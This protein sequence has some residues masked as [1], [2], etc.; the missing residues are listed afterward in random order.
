[1][2]KVSKVRGKSY[3]YRVAN[4]LSNRQGWEGSF[5]IPLSGASSRIVQEIAGH[6]VLANHSSGIK[7]ACECKKTGDQFIRLEYKWLEK[8]DFSQ[9]QWRKVLIFAFDRSPHY[10]LIPYTQYVE[11]NK[12]TT[13]SFPVEPRFLARGKGFYIIHWEELQQ[14]L[15]DQQAFLLWKSYNEQYAF[16]TLDNYIQGRETLGIN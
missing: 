6:D 1:M 5:R 4:W 2:G 9:F 7:I 12:S 14:A 11:F 10:V 15:Q 3:E 8:I 13:I 16:M